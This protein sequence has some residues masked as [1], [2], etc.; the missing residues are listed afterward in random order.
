MGRKSRKERIWTRSWFA[1]LYSGNWQNAPKQ[2]CVHVCQV[3]KSGPTLGDPVDCSRPGSSVH[4]DAPGK[5]T[6]V[7][8][9]A[10]LQGIF[11]QPR[12]RTCQTHKTCLLH[13]L[14][15]QMG[16]LPAKP[17][18]VSYTPVKIFL[19]KLTSMDK[20]APL[21]NLTPPGF[22]SSASHPPTENTKM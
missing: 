10:L 19:K 12:D 21:S 6:G 5:H 22:I 4:G 14:P 8:C 11:P 3:A 9:H 13:L 7:G 17:K 20:T 18:A 2:P 16:S 15:W 1:L